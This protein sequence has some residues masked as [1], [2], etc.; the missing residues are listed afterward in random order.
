VRID[1]GG[2]SFWTWFFRDDG[3]LRQRAANAS[4][5]MRAIVDDGDLRRAPSPAV[6][7]LLA[8]AADLAKLCTVMTP[9]AVERAE[10]AIAAVRQAAGPSGSAEGSWH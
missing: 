5:A 8:A 4:D 2:M 10:R 9:E 7:E 1:I 3:G 6:E